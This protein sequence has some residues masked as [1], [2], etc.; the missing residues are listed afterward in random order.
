MLRK[1]KEK[2]AS[3]VFI[4]ACVPPIIYFLQHSWAHRREAFVPEYPYEVLTEESDYDTFFRQTGLGRSAVDKLLGAGDFEKILEVQEDFRRPVEVSCT[5][6][7]G[8]FTREDKL[9]GQPKTAGRYVTP[10]SHAGIGG[11]SQAAEEVL[12]PDFVDLQPGDILLTLSTHSLGWRHGHEGLVMDE[13][14]TLECAMLGT[15]SHFC[16]VQHWRE[17][18]QYIVLR[19]K[20]VSLEQRQEVAAYACEVLHGVPYHLSSG[21]IGPKAPDPNAEYFGLQCAYL[22]WYAWNHFGYDLDSDG[23]RL[24]TS[25]DIL[26]SDLLEVVQVYGVKLP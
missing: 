7:I 18:A 3:L 1:L 24:V 9:V 10:E 16:S 19:V 6:M 2:I 21:F 12:G 11:R 25:T 8:W 4:L 23:G 22:A 13:E 14:T 20:G 5:P 15:D 17:C 26:Q